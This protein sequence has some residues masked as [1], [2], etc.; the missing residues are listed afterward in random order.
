MSEPARIIQFPARFVEGER[1]EPWVNENVI[2]RHFSVSARTV[3][4]WMKSGMP[5]ELKGGSR[6]YKISAC[7]RWHEENA[8]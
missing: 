3:R 7:E 2:A 5:S 6:R 8:A 4:R 1:Y